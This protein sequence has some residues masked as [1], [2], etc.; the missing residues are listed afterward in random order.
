[1]IIH[2]SIVTSGDMVEPEKDVLELPPVSGEIVQVS[3]FL[4]AWAG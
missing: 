2:L 3:G 1:M 4:Y